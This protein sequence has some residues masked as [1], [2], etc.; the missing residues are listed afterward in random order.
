MTFDSKFENIQILDHRS[1]LIL[2][3]FIDTHI[4]FPQIQIIGSYA[5][6]LLEWLKNYTFLEEQKYK[7]LSYSKIAAKKFFDTR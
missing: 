4:H 3:G 2:P 1:N 7:D 5:S 6:N